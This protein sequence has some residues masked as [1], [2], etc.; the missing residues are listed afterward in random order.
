MP[1]LLELQQAM[2]ASLVDRD[3]GAAAAML[4]EN[5]PPDRLNIYRNTFVTGVTKALR[6]SYPAVH[7]LVGAEFF[8]GA[9]G[10]F[11]ARHPPR[12]AYL[13]AYGADF[14]DFL[15]DFQPAHRWRICQMSR[16]SNGPSTAPFMR[17]MSNRSTWRGFRCFRL[18]IKFASA[19]CR[20]RRLPWC[21][22]T[23]RPMSSGGAC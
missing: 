16:A 10:L 18:K 4:A 2:R 9:A 8:E 21:A 1:T 7:R 14:P 15:R 12:S 22:P 19:S 5:V 6:L 11:V 23:I 20:I 17:P 3:D 13:D